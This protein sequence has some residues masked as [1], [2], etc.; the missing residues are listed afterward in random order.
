MA[1]L[2]ASCIDLRAELRTCNP[3][4]MHRDISYDQVEL[5]K[6]PGILVLS[7]QPE[8]EVLLFFCLS[9]LDSGLVALVLIRG[10]G[11][12]AFRKLIFLGVLNL[13]GPVFASLL[14]RYARNFPQ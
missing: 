3:S 12:S 13:C 9:T 4:R 5:L 8:K 14:L 7:W 2:P 6:Y 11:F 1:G 10:A